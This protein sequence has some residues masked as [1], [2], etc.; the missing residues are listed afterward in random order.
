L[1]STISLIST[2]TGFE[3]SLAAPPEENIINETTTTKIIG[4]NLN[5]KIILLC[6]FANLELNPTKAK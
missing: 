3:F 4:R 2:K 1:F 5:T 6:Q